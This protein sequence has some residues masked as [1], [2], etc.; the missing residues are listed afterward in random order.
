M[1]ID[2]E[3]V[4]K[5]KDENVHIR[6]LRRVLPRKIKGNIFEEFLATRTADD[7]RFL[8][9][10][11]Q[12]ITHSMPC[13]DGQGVFYLLRSI[14]CQIPIETVDELLKCDRAT[15]SK[16]SHFFSHYEKQE[17]DG[18]Y[19]LV[20]QPQSGFDEISIL[21]LLKLKENHIQDNVK[22]QLSAII[23]QGD[24]FEKD[25]M[26]IASMYVDIGH[27]YFF[28]HKNEHVPGMM[29][30][31]SAR[32]LMIACS[33]VYGHV[34]LE[35][36]N[37]IVNEIHTEFKGYVELSFPSKFV[38]TFDSLTENRKGYWS[39]FHSV[40]TMFQ[41]NVEVAVVKFTA[42]I[43]ERKV[44]D[45]LRKAR[46]GEDALVRFIPASGVTHRINLRDKE[47]HQYQ[48][49][50]LDVSEQG[51]LLTFDEDTSISENEEYEFIIYIEDAGNDEFIFGFCK[52]KWTEISEGGLM[53]G[54][55]FS[56][57]DQANLKN[58][59]DAIKRNFQVKEEREII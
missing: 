48:A 8:L 36:V 41:K 22:A 54:F 58:L 47:K 4:H 52:V 37:F 1:L 45:K 49:K 26:F 34:P 35:K 50:I 53:A 56:A 57:L 13:S 27:P 24:G 7:Q 10:N 44:F 5:E 59:K 39:H 3:F 16:C 19:R 23:E 43:I 30:V 29:I 2:K 15:G 20:K 55:Y 28:E 42:N 9:E 11:Y 12:K 31:E 33:H 46:N 21:Q 17:Q 38:V 40:V 6:N 51:F 18:Y 14:P 25:E 32:Q